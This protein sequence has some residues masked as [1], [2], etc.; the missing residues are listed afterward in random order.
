MAIKLFQR[1]TGK[2]LDEITQHSGPLTESDLQQW[3]VARIAAIAK[4]TPEE[5]DVNRPFADFGLDSIQMF[6]LSNDLEKF[7]GHKV[8]EVVAWDYPT[9]SQLAGHLLSRGDSISVSPNMML[10][11]EG[12]W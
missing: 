4:L 11:N 12:N 2:K 9:I 10:P 1:L 8:S 3:M 7:L 5:V 6:G